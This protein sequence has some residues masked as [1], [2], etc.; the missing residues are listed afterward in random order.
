MLFR[1]NGPASGTTQ[2]TIYGLS[3]GAFD[4]T[5]LVTKLFSSDMKIICHTCRGFHDDS[6]D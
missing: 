1:P 5:P 4:I 3:F 2:I 6:Y